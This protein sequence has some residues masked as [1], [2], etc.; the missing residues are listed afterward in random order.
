MTYLY[1][2]LAL[3]VFLAGGAMLYH[4]G[5]G[6]VPKVLKPVANVWVSAGYDPKWVNVGLWALFALLAG[7]MLVFIGIP[8]YS[9]L[10][11]LG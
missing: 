11:D 7:M 6:R 9:S 8:L 3:L 5:S 2:G 10:S 4:L 1:S